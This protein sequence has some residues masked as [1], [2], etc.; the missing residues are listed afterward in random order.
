[1]ESPPKI[2][3]DYMGSTQLHR[4]KPTM[5]DD[6]P[7]ENEQI[8]DLSA[9]RPVNNSNAVTPPPDDQPINTSVSSE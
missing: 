7:T 1:M 5:Q 2:V 4:Q 6:L 9:R 8:E 3:F